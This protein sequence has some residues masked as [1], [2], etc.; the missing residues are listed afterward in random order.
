[1]NQ[2]NWGQRALSLIAAFGVAVSAFPVAAFAETATP[3]SAVAQDENVLIDL[4][5][6]GDA[7]YTKVE[8]LEELTDGNYV[9]V[10][11]DYAMT[12]LEDSKNP[13][14]LSAKVTEEDLSAAGVWTIDVAQQD[15]DTVAKLTDAAGKTVAPKG[16]DTNGIK[17]GEYWWKVG[18][19]NGKFTFGGDGVLLASNTGNE[20]KFRAYKTTTINGGYP[21]EFTVYKVPGG[22]GDQP[23]TSPS[24]S[25]STQPSPSPSTEPTTAPSQKPEQGIVQEGFEQVTTADGLTTGHY[26]LVADGYQPTIKNGTWVEAKALESNKLDG[27][28]WWQFN[29]TGNTITLTD[30][31][32]TAIAPAGGATNGIAVGIY[33]WAWVCNDN[34]TFTF[35]GQGDDTVRL[36]ANVSN[37]HKL[38]AYKTGT[39]GSNYVDQFQ[40]YRDTTYTAPAPELNLVDGDVISLYHP[41]SSTAVNTAGA[42]VE[43]E[44]NEDGKVVSTGDVKYVVETAEGGY[45]FKAE[46]NGKYLTSGATGNSLSLTE[47]ATAYSVWNVEPA[48]GGWYIINAA[49]EYKGNKQYLEYYDGAFKPYGFNATGPSQYVFRLLPVGVRKLNPSDVV[50]A[51]SPASGASVMV[52]DK[53]TLTSLDGVSIFYTTD[54]TEPQANNDAQAYTGPIT[55]DSV[56]FTVKAVGYL[57]ASEDQAECTGNV[58]TFTYKEGDTADGYQPYFGQLHAHTNIS[59]G[60]GSIE[61]AYEHGSKLDTLDFLAITDHSNSFDNDKDA[62]IAMGNDCAV[63]EEW[64]G[65]HKA[66]DDATTEEFVG[67]YGYEMTWSDGFGHMNT[68]R[69][70]G[71]ESRSNAAFGNGSGNTAGYKLYYDTLVSVDGALAQFN[72]PGTTFGDF[73]DFAFYSAAIDQRIKLIEV[74]NGEGAVGS[75]GYFP[76]YEY[77]T[78]ALDKGW[79]VAPTNNQDNHKGNWGDSNTTRSVVL[80]KELTRDAIYDAIDNYRVYAT[81]DNDLHIVYSLNDHVMGSIIGKQD[82]I[83]IKATITDPTDKD[84]AK[85][86]VIVNGGKVVAS[87]TL[88]GCQGNVEFA[89]DSND[90]SYYYLRVTQADKD[91]AVTAPVWTGEGVSAGLSGLSVD[92]DLIVKDEPVNVTAAVYNNTMG[93]MEVTG[94]TFTEGDTVLKA[95]TA[96]EITEAGL[97]AVVSGATVNYTLPF[98][99]SKAGKTTIKANLTVRVG[100][101][102]HEFSESVAFSVTDPSLVTRILVDGTHYN[103][104]VTGYYK[105]NMGNFSTLAAGKNAKVT[106]KQPGETITA[107]DLEGVSMLV[108]SAP[109]KKLANGVTPTVENATFSEGFIQMVAD[110]AKNGGTV[111]LCGIADYQDDS[112]GAPFASTEQINPILV[113]MGSSL[114][115]NDDEVLDDDTAY[116]G[117]STQTYRVYMDNFNTAEVPALFEGMGD[118]RYSAYSGASVDVGETGTWLVKGSANCYS[119]NS[120]ARTNAG[121]WDSGKPTGSTATGSYNEETAVVKKGDVVTLATEAVGKGRVYVAGTVFLSDFE[122]SDGSNV[123]YGDASYANKIILNNILDG[124]AA[125]PEVTDIATVRAA[126]TGAESVGKVFTVEGKVTAGNVAPNAF[127]DTIYIQDATGGLDIYPVA[128]VN[129]ASDA[130]AILPGQTVRVTGALDEYQ[131]DI[132]LRAI[133]I[134]RIDASTDSKVEPTP[135]SLTEAGNYGKNGGL[136]AKVTGTVKA[137]NLESGLLD[138]VTLTDGKGNEYRLLFNNYIGYSDEPSKKLEELISNGVTLSAVGVV[139]TDP[140]GVCLRVRDLSEVSITQNTEP[141]EPTATPEP[142]AP[143]PT[144]VVPNEET[145]GY[146][147]ELSEEIVVSGELDKISDLDT[148]EEI[149]D[150]LAAQ[151]QTQNVVTMEVTLYQK[152]SDGTTR[153]VFAEDFPEGGVTLTLPYPDGTSAEAHD[154]VVAHMF[155][156]SVKGKHNAGDIECPAVTKTENGLQFT[157][158]GLS[159]IAIG[160]TEAVV[161]TATPE[162]TSVPGKPVKPIWQ[163]W[164]EEIFK[165][166]PKPTP[167]PTTTPEPTVAPIPTV[168]PTTT[169]E[170]TSVPGKPVK[171]IWQSWLEEI[172]KPKPKPTPVPTV[173][174]APTAEPIVT[175]EPTSVPAKPV[176]PG[177]GGFWGNL[178]G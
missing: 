156:Y 63:S 97:A 44:L 82:S 56:P 137:F 130:G 33:D 152:D 78:R 70:P 88:A 158:T 176:K 159:P 46:S 9:M 149:E 155:A 101:A 122:I 68:F 69:T 23:T 84:D 42:A 135:L 143:N 173:A 73:Q 111:I 52:G 114:R 12:V 62:S 172:F 19:D 109:L 85:V 95:L 51:A 14:V 22:S 170:P 163:S 36:A 25:P 128:T 142:V 16:A 153:L 98:A 75:S 30:S 79:H 160:W 59:D 80:T 64:V 140:D 38:R 61:D 2:R 141:V 89:L 45:R 96:D 13:W 164:L 112:E 124:V 58:M 139:Y 66:A 129:D 53:V 148:P 86:E 83:S 121:E 168:A 145:N 49:A 107:A 31:Q 147:V 126:Y 120:R 35:K 169:P 133:K 26:V 87:Q 67:I 106:I 94:L 34:G 4:L 136:L 20:N 40:L 105:D 167:V 116:N 132:E 144:P 91:I 118:K 77:Y 166:K 154:F 48:A 108:V 15:E 10:A 41:A 24:P 7:T 11:G 1:M 18:V 21:H 72:H 131:G 171:P 81:E 115:L 151:L 54:G 74:G 113:A 57:A 102:T 93:T 5:E 27:E 60:A 150:E 32:G 123:D 119:I 161:P 47:E 8:T 127:Y 39:T 117:G 76:S 28:F 138:T 71:F 178:F 165:P 43:A 3:E 134:E 103:D 146:L 99:P 174:P 177:F 100:D 17:A 37:D 110:Y 125:E 90:Y 104:Y 157:V 6:T 175:P 29:V 55:V 162:P 92:A 50:I 65:A